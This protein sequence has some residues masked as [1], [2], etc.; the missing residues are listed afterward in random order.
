MGL[1]FDLDQTIIDSSLAEP[2]RGKNWPEAYSKIPNFTLFDGIREAFDLIRE[3][4]IP[5]IIVTSSPSNYCIKVLNHWQIPYDNV[6][7]Y[8]DTK[9]KKPHP[10]PINKALTLFTEK[11]TKVISFGDR[12]IDIIASKEANVISVGCTWGISDPAPLINS[13]PNH[14]INHPSEIIGLVQTYFPAEN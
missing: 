8:H 1:I 14:I 10:E 9:F 6:V 3:R 2:Y 13:S 4:G 12:D 11:P 7:C 5:I